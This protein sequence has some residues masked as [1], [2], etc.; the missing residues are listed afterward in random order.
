VSNSAAPPEEARSAS[1]EDRILTLFKPCFC[2]VPGAGTEQIRGC[3]PFNNQRLTGLIDPLPLKIINENKA[4]RNV[5]LWKIKGGI[6][7][8]VGRMRGCANMHENWH[9][10][11]LR[12]TFAGW[13]S[14]F[15]QLVAADELD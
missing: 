7:S 2:G 1:A 13:N 11:I 8:P 4:L 6:A 12:S 9:L 3:C 5:L 14:P 15:A 10:P